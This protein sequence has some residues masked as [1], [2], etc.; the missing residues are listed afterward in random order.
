MKPLEVRGATTSEGWGGV[1]DTCGADRV[2]PRGVIGCVDEVRVG[3]LGGEGYG[4]G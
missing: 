1:E 4:E 3:C 2:C